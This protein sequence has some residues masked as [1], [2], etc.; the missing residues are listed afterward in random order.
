[1]KK[2]VT[3]MALSTFAALSL[4]AAEVA[5]QHEAMEHHHEKS[6]Y[7]ALKGIAT[8]G[9]TMSEEHAILDG[10]AGLGFGVDLGY[11]LPYGFAVEIDVTYVGNTVTETNAVAEQEEISATYM[12]SSLDLAYKYHL[13]REFGLVGKVGYEYELEQIDTKEDESDTGFIFAAALEYEVAEDIA[14]LGE[15]EHS[16][17]DGP[18]GDTLY[19]GVVFDF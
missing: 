3:L 1:M 16:T 11:K 6:F 17:I 18:R 13:T 5:E 19:A 2:I 8:L 12:T 14:I 7:V 9:D 10:D 4:N 15:Y